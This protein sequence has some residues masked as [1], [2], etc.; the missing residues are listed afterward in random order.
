MTYPYHEWFH[1]QLMIALH[2]SGRRGEA[3][4]AFRTARQLLN[5]H[6]GLEPSAYLRRV[7]QGILED[8]HAS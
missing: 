5:D 2:R 6:L 3:L 1:V 7:H 4:A 8:V